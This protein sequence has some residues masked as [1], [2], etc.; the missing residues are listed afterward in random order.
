MQTALA[1]R[2]QKDATP[3]YVPRVLLCLVV[4]GVF[5][6]VVVVL[7]S[8]VV[9]FVVAAAVAATVV[10][11]CGGGD[12]GEAVSL[13][14]WYCGRRVVHVHREPKFRQAFKKHS[15][16]QTLHTTARVAKRLLLSSGDRRH[17]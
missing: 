15:H 7:V 5:V 13:W 6:V 3:E 8:G 14:S 16:N 11:V 1:G 2:R 10:D 4:V 12:G 17:S 9:V